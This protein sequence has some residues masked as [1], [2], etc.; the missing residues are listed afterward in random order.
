MSSQGLSGDHVLVRG[1]EAG[2]IHSACPCTIVLDSDGLLVLYLALGTSCKLRD[3]WRYDLPA[4]RQ[5]ITLRDVIWRHNDLLIHTPSTLHSVML[6][7][8]ADGSQRDWYV[9][10]HSPILRTPLGFDYT[11]KALDI[12]VSP[13]LDSWEWKDEDH[14]SSAQHSVVGQ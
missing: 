7:R 5:S 2:V 8:N 9:N 11:D 14:F 12:L 3:G 1:V 6:R 4:S 13:N 10:L